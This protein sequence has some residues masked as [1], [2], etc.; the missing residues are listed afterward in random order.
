MNELLMMH[1]VSEEFLEVLGGF[2]WKDVTVEE[3][4]GTPFWTR[5]S[6]EK[7]QLGT[8]DQYGVMKSG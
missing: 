8:K 1:D 6:R 2:H 4:L 3:A 5:Y 7:D